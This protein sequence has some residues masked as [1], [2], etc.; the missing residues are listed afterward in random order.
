[1]VGDVG[2]T[3]GVEGNAGG[4]PGTMAGRGKAG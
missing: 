2:K 4:E 1:M 3:G